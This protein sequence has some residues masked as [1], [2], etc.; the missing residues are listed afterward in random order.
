[1]GRSERVPR[2][3]VGGGRRAGRIA[4]GTDSALSMRHVAVDWRRQGLKVL[5]REGEGVLWAHGR[6]LGAGL[7]VAAVS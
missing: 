6:A 7:L 5:E 3:R 2:R 4:A 1:M